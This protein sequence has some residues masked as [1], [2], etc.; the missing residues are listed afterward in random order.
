MGKA[1][2]ILSTIG[3]SFKD[4][5]GAPRM[6]STMA[7]YIANIDP[8]PANTEYKHPR[9]HKHNPGFMDMEHI[10][11]ASLDCQPPVFSR[12]IGP[13]TNI[14]YLSFLHVV[15]GTR[16]ESNLHKQSM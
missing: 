6:W 3:Q 11:P 12:S 9:I 7:H 16:L 13:A 1:P 14:I 8:S 10:W 2:Q 5:D 4:A 15:L